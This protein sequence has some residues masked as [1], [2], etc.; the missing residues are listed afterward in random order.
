MAGQPAM[1]RLGFF[2][3]MIRRP[4]RSTLFPY[5]TLFRSPARWRW[6]KPRWPPAI[7]PTARFSSRPRERPWAPAAWWCILIRTCGSSTRSNRYSG[8]TQQNCRENS[9]LDHACIMKSRV[10]RDVSGTTFRCALAMVAIHSALAQS[11]VPPEKAAAA[12]AALIPRPGE[13]TLRCRVE[14]I[15]P[16]PLYTVPEIAAGF[17]YSLP[18]AQYGNSRPEHGWSVVA[19]FS[20][21]GGAENYFSGHIDVPAPGPDTVSGNWAYLVKSED[22]RVG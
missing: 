8:D 15:V 13:R 1:L 16:S 17:T 20:P 12:R 11:P 3:L 4:P 5:T 14:P 19:G 7:P 18:L 21:D 9:A 10:C 6:C 22:R 2:F